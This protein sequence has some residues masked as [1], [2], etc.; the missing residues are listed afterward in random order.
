M[1]TFPE[2]CVRARSLSL[3]FAVACAAGAPAQGFHQQEPIRYAVA[4]DDN[5]ITRLD[6]RLAAGE[7]ELV[8]EGPSGRLRPLL[9]ALG[10]PLSSQTL[11]FSKTSLQRH[12]ISQRNPRALYFGPDVY[13]G[14][15]PGAA[16]L[17]VIAGDARLGF[18]FYRLP[19]DPAV[20]G[21]FQRDDSCLSCHAS[22]RTGDEPGLLLRS[23]FPDAEGDPIASAG[24]TQVTTSTPIGER[25]GGWLVTGAF[26]GTHRGNGTATRDDQGRWQVAGRAA[27]DLR[28]FGGQFDVDCYPAATSDVAALLALEQQATVH[29]VLVQASL[30]L[31]VALARDAQLND[32]LHESGMRPPTAR[33]LDALAR[34]I[35]SALLLADEPSLV[36]HRAAPDAAFAAAFAS[37]WPRDAA[38]VA[39]GR[40]DLRERTFVLPMSPMVH[41]PAFAAL[42]EPLRA[43]V[44]ERLRIVCDRG[45]LPG[46]VAV[47]TAQRRA[48]HAHLTELVPGYAVR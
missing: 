45:R 16:A 36:E 3:T 29:N 1:R 44:L 39:L 32:V 8:P 37:L 6:Q 12:R 9:Q 46:G 18:V 14:W 34:E 24:E 40:F 43:R 27:A 30:R 35:A 19:Q 28:A 10:V 42:P 23:V 13:V 31:R 17:E 2:A 7:V 5:A 48:L 15:V 20:P 11:V 33:L 4:K 38:G 26:A 47:T 25:W 21:R 41:S 22:P